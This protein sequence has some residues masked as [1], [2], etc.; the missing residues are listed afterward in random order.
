MAWVAAAIVGSAVVGG[1]ISSKASKDASNAQVQG[2]DSA[3]QAQVIASQNAAKA[4]TDAA[5]LSSDTAL[6]MSKESNS[7]IQRQYDQSRADLEPWRTAGA[8]ALGELSTGLRPDGTFNRDFTLS[9]FV[10]DPGYQFRMDEGS[11]ALEGSAA[12]RG[13]MLSGGT[14]KALSRYGQDYASGEYSSA[15]NRWNADNDRRFNRLSGVAGTGQTTAQQVASL[16]ANSA[17]GQATNNT[18]AGGTM[19]SSYGRAG[20]ATASGYLNSGAATAAGYINSGNARAS[21]IVGSANAFNGAMGN[22]VNGYQSYQMLNNLK[23]PAPA[24][25]YPTTD[26]QSFYS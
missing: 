22:A 23:A 11:R 24:Y 19:A 10:K 9:D 4:Q 1:V 18:A 5:K 17:S 3:A 13:T 12:A 26:V 6:Q 8:D 15:Y 7:L 25:Q 14:L 2:A 21:G 20:D 16:G